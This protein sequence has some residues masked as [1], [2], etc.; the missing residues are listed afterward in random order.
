MLSFNLGKKF[1]SLLH[2]MHKFFDKLIS[3]QDKHFS[4]SHLHLMI[5]LSSNSPLGQLSTQF[6]SFNFFGDLHEIQFELPIVS[7]LLHFSQSE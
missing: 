1:C 3:E 4:F 2:E 6:P 5:P 7:F